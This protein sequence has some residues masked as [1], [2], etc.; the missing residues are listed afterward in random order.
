VADAVELSPPRVQRERRLLSEWAARR[1]PASP[2][3][4]QVRVGAIQPNTQAAGLT[5]TEMKSLGVWRRYADALVRLPGSLVL[6]EASMAAHPGYISQ[7]LL[8]RRLLPLTPELADMAAWPVRM[9]YLVA[10]E[11]PVVTAMARD[12][13]IDVEVYRP[14]WAVAFI[15]DLEARKQRPTKTGGLR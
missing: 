11:D 12:V 6:I 8:Y 13:S 3:E 9:V 15:A 7:L 2:V 1:Y 10:L 4:H 5:Y 14:P